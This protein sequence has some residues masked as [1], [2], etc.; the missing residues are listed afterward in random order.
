MKDL[1]EHP[2][3]E[4]HPVYESPVWHGFKDEL[5]V[6]LEPNLKQIRDAGFVVDLILRYG[7]PVQE[8]QA[9]ITETE[10]DLVVMA[11]KGHTGLSRAI[12]GSVAET[13]V[14]RL[15]RPILIVKPECALP[16]N[17]TEVVV[18]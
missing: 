14:K 4:T 16:A 7:D 11:S 9:Q 1:A 13:L 2:N 17:A 5:T 15:N 8:I 3:P 10:V 6:E 12:S 18:A